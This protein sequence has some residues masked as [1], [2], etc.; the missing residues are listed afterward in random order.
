MLVFAGCEAGGS[1]DNH[2]GGSHVVLEAESTGDSVT[3][4][5]N[6]AKIVQLL[7]AR[8]EESGI[9]ERIVQRR[10]GRQI[11]VQLPKV[12]WD[13]LDYISTRGL[14]EFKGVLASAASEE[15]L[16]K[17]YPAGLPE[18]TQIVEEKDEDGD[19][20]VRVYLVPEGAELDGSMLRDARLGF[21]RR[22]RPT[23]YFEFN[24]EGAQLFGE[25]TGAH[26]GEPLAMIVDG[27]VMSAPLIQDRIGRRGMINGNFTEQ[28]AKSL[29]RVLRLGPYP[30]RVTVVEA[31]PLTKDIWLGNGE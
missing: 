24:D 23:V 15:D 28:E 3:D 13:V 10:E 16:K 4:A 30:V 31:K 5:R 7:E 19:A 9:G 6:V 27:Q 2:E 1:W 25:Y 22:V 21:D 14:L 18:D 26:I 12:D 17:Q 29:A 8:L 20:T 11:V